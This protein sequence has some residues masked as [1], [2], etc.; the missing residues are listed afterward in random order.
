MASAETVKESSTPGVSPDMQALIAA[1]PKQMTPEELTVILKTISESSAAGMK[2]SLRPENETHPGISAYSYP[3][4]EVA[5]PKPTLTRETFFVGGRLREETLTPKE[6]ELC[7]A[8]MGDR[9]SRGGTWPATDARHG[10]HERLFINVPCKTVDDRMN[11]PSFTQVLVELQ[12][13]REAASPEHLIDRVAQLEAQ[14]LAMAGHMK[15]GAER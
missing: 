6:I 1:L 2:R 8:L 3:E 15:V 10:S 14:L 7:N 5:R 4:G 13:G 12:Q 11:L 9:E